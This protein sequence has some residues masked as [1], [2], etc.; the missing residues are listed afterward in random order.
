MKNTEIRYFKNVNE[1]EK[2]HEE[3][4]NGINFIYVIAFNEKDFIDQISKKIKERKEIHEEIK[5]LDDVFKHVEYV[6][7]T[8]Y[9]MTEDI[10]KIKELNE[11]HRLEKEEN[12][13]NESFLFNEILKE[14]N[15][16]EYGDTHEEYETLNALGKTFEDLEN[17]EYFSRVWKKAEEKC[18]KDFE[19]WMNRVYA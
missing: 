16:H 13:K 14:M 3:D 17:D 10:E 19:N 4:M 7:D 9:T 15:Q 8:C 2:A 12:R 5:T 18:F 6:C 1:M 11:L